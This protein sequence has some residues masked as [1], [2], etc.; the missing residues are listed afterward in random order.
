MGLAEFDYDIEEQ[1]YQSLSVSNVDYG[2][3]IPS[4]SSG[5]ELIEFLILP[6]SEVSPDDFLSESC[7]TLMRP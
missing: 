7:Y 3:G 2:M 4:I 5:D 1:Y 6:I